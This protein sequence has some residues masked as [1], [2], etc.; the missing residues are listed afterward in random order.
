MLTKVIVHLTRLK[1][2][3]ISQTYLKFVVWLEHLIKIHLELY[4]KYFLGVFLSFTRNEI[5][6]NLIINIGKNDVLYYI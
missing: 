6:H 3:Q 5:F 2:S 1:L 4:E